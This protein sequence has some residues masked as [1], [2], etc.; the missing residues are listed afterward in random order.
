MG[1]P[2]LITARSPV[3]KECGPRLSSL[4]FEV[5][6]HDSDRMLHEEQ[7]SP[8]PDGAPSLSRAL[9]V[10]ET[11]LMHGPEIGVTRLASLLN[12]NKAALQRLLS[13][14]EARGYVQRSASTH[15]YSLGVRLFELGAHFQNQLDIRRAALPELASMVN[16]TGQAGF[17]CVRDHDQALCLERI[18]GRHFVRIF[19]LR[20]G[21]RQPLHCGAAPRALLSGLSNDDILAYAA[22]TGLPRYTP[23]TL[24]TAQQLLNDADNTR[25]H[26]YVVSNEDVS[27]GIGAVG[28]P[29]LDY[30]DKVV[31]SISLS[32][33]AA[34]Y[35]PERIAELAGAVAAAAHRISRQMG[36]S[37]SK[38]PR[39]AAAC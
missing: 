4:V 31:A 13:T 9:D 18:E 25:T 28:A 21:E 2:R 14:L 27:P 24:V 35:T 32:G 8:L 16:D 7:S 15:K 34:T 1:R 39:R 17:L 29:V 6:V 23:Q 11:F 3:D 33:I 36:S 19:A 22:R 5:Y 37:G 20:L 38:T 12:M 30:T 10:L 26:G